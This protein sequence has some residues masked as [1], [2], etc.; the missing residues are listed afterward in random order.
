[1]KMRA[2]MIPLIT[3]DPYFSVWSPDE[4][5]NVAAA[6]HWTQASNTLIGSVTVDGKEYSFVGYQHEMHKMRQVSLEIDA[7]TTTAVFENDAI[8]LTAK[9]MTPLLPDDLAVMTRPVS[10]L[11]LSY[12][13]RDGGTHTVTA[14]IRVG[15]DMC[16]N[17]QNQSPIIR[18]EVKLAG[19]L[20]GMRMGNT[21]QKPLN[22]S[23]DDI[24]ID[25][26]YLYLA[27]DDKDAVLSATYNNRHV[28]RQLIQ[29]DCGLA[30]GEEKLF[31]FAYDDIYSIEYF[32]KHLKSYWNKDGKTIETA[33]A[34]ACAD[35]KQVMARCDA[36]AKKLYADADRVGGEKYAEL[37]SLAYR[38][39]IAAHKVVLDEN[40]EILFISKECNSNGCA[41]TVDVSYPSIPLFLLY[42]PELVKGMMRPIYRYAASDAWEYDFAPHDVGTYP[43]VNGQTYGQNKREY[44]MP[45]E[46][47]GNMIVMET[48]VALAT[49]SADFAAAH[50]DLLKIWCDYLLRYGN[51]PEDQL[52]TDDFAGRLAHNCNLS[53]KAIMGVAGMSILCKM[54][55][56]DA[57][58]ADYR[59]KAEAMTANWMATARYADG[60]TKL[61]FVDEGDTF[62]MKYNMV[63]DKIWGTGLFTQA[64]RDEELAHNQKHF[65]EYG[66]PLDNRAEYTKSDWLVWT[67]TMASDKAT[68]E[69]FIA[70][71]WKAYD[72]SSSRVAMT[73]WYDTVSARI[74]SFK[75]RSVQGGLYIRLLDEAWADKR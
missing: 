18:E 2:P 72:E 61:T 3:V 33:I 70:P 53:L 1:M 48:N 38:Q 10:Y 27:V 17:T 58:A 49:G 47:C 11:A 56:K 35:Y 37:L 29:A 66:M 28:R 34:E 50:F 65:N 71:L 67:A 42:N 15:E 9:F 73:D 68:F 45:V 26:G 64:F 40:G 51:D 44:Q 6:Q 30:A 55:G 12:V 63:W 23:G 43:L 4:K 16:L 60:S 20:R 25:W 24:R 41:A 21:E 74:C 75:H 59:Q 46:E 57:E 39:V 62:S 7:L 36:F 13:S 32:G 22:R 69:K 14:T 5:L 8:T 54:L 52:C 19:N 31:L